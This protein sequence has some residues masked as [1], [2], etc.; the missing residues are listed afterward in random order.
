MLQKALA[1]FATPGP[2][3][4]LERK[5]ERELVRRVIG[6]M[7]E[8]KRHVFELFVQQDHLA[9]FAADWMDLGRK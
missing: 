5:T 7:P 2:D 9:G 3:T 8:D 4:Q 1:G 6:E